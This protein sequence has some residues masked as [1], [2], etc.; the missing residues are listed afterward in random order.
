MKHSWIGRWLSQWQ[1]QAMIWPSILLMIVFSFI[2]MFGLIIAFQD[3]SPLSGFTGSEFVGLDNFK[4]FFGDEG[5]YNVLINTLAISLLKLLIGFPLEIVLAI[6]IN[7]LSMGFFKRFTQTVS[8]LPHFLSW[9]ILGGMIISWLNSS[10]LV[11]S[12]LLSTHIIEEPISFLANESLYWWV[13][14]L[15]DIWKEVGWGTILYLAAITGIDPSLYEA[16]KVDGAQF[17]KRIWHVTLPG[18][19]NIIV[20][21][22][23][24]R[25]GSVLGS[26]LEQTL[27]LQNASNM[28]R[29]EVIDSYVYH[30]GLA[31]GDFSFATAVGIFSSV[32]S[33]TLLLMANFLTKRFSDSSI[34]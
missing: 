32:V 20:L 14:V 3:Y 15:S 33:V 25:V 17:F 10:G 1:L 24:L 21:M 22:F 4:A 11:N 2:P 12:L 16:A 19:R 30:L 13:A 31:Q 6:M 18:M 7:Q 34:F 9:V 23:V 28:G 27:V 5:F 29:S 26:N 8:Y